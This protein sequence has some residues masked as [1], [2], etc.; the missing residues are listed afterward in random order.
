V[1][2]FEATDDTEGFVLAQDRVDVT[3]VVDATNG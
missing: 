1:V 3:F 2:T